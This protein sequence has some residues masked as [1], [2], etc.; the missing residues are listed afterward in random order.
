[1]HDYLRLQT[2]IATILFLFICA[3]IVSL[4]VVEYNE[5][6]TVAYIVA[7]LDQTEDRM[8]TIA[9]LTSANGAD[10]E[11]SKII[12][13]CERRSEY[14]SLLNSLN[15]LNKK[16]LLRVQNLSESCGDFFAAR[17]ALM[18][19]KL[20]REY[21]EYELLYTMLSRFGNE[22]DYVDTRKSWK[23]IV[24]LEVTR[25]SLLREQQEIQ[26]KIISL[27]LTGSSVNSK[28]I[29]AL[30]SEAQNIYELLTVHSLRINTLREELQK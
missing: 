16:D 12:M 10:E 11:V 24:E 22:K 2:K 5:R 18:V 25:S 26:D 21:D 19:S 27:L 17:K 7:R 13:D 4:L 29:T 6:A 8:R 23:E 20:S 15:T 1:M 3:A 9:D 30:V 14:E 28:E